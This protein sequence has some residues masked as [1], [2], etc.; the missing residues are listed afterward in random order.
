[1]LWKCLLKQTKV[2]RKLNCFGSVEK[3]EKWDKKSK[4]SFTCFVSCM[5]RPMKLILFPLSSHLYF[6][7]SPKRKSK[8]FDRWND[9]M[10]VTTEW[11]HDTVGHVTTLSKSLRYWYYVTSYCQPTA[12]WH[13]SMVLFSFHWFL[14]NNF[15]IFQPVWLSSFLSI[16][17]KSKW[18]EMT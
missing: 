18:S 13:R 12:D 5:S 2:C 15:V 3:L 9:I 17:R 16:W 14:M 1:M 8:S 4:S 10:S 11:R 7:T 6:S